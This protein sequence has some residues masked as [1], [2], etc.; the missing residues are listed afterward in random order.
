MKTPRVSISFEM[1]IVLAITAV[2]R[3]LMVL[4]I[5]TAKVD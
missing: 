1:A 2:R 5:H 3:W 4:P